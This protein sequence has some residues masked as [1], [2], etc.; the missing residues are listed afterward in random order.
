M[1]VTPPIVFTF[2]RAGSTNANVRSC[3]S[4]T[5]IPSAVA[6]RPAGPRPTGMSS[7]IRFGRGSIRTMD[8]SCAV[9]SGLEVGVDLVLDGLRSLLVELLRLRSQARD[10]PDVGES[11]PSPELQRG[12]EVARRDE[13]LETVMVERRGRQGEQV[14]ASSPADR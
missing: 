3:S 7:T 8:W 11:G 14:A 5:Q 1:S 4:A 13:L 6:I 10:V 12:G 9:T 2:R